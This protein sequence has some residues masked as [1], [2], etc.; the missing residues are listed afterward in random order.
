MKKFILIFPVLFSFFLSYSQMKGDNEFY[1]NWDFGMPV[2]NSFVNQFSARG[3]NFGYGKFI[4]DGLAVGLEF[5]WNN[6]YEFTPE[7]T[8]QIQNG[9]ATTD[10]YKYIYTVPMTATITKFFK[11]GDMFEPY[12]R[13]GLGAQ[14]SEQNLYYNIYETPNEN[15]G[16]VAIPELGTHL[17][18]GGNKS[19]AVN[20]SVRYKF[21]TNSAPSFDLNNLQTLNFNVGFAWVFD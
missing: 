17:H 3:G 18:F 14:Y 5:G 4:K 21:S 7:K 1:L 10:L 20:L 12:V 6:Y 9:A 15:W 16:F 11:A 2:G 13:L 19:W 8:Y